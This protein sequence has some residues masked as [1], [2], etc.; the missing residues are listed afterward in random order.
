[1]YLFPNHP[2]N[3]DINRKEILNGTILK[4]LKLILIAVS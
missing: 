2:V 3:P 1:M 4:D